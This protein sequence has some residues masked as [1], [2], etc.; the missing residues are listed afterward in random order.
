MGY[1]CLGVFFDGALVRLYRLVK[2]ACAAQGVSLEEP[3]L[4]SHL[5]T[6]FQSPS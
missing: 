4:R 1:G 3:L 6:D 5:S 2:L